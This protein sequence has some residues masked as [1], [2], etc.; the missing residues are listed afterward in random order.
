MADDRCPGCKQDDCQFHAQGQVRRLTA[1]VAKLEAALRVIVD[2]HGP[3]TIAGDA[4][5][6]ALE[7]RP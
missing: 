4:A 2:T 6:I 1:R 5:R 3:G 7:D